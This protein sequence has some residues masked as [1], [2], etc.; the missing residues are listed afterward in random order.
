MTMA[1][2]IIIN[3]DILG[4]EKKVSMEHVLGMFFLKLVNMLQL[5]RKYA[6]I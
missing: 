2:N 1:L 3:Y 6:R 4:M 5:K